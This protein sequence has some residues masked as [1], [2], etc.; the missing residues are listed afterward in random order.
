MSSKKS[1]SSAHHGVSA[2]LA[3]TDTATKVAIAKGYVA[4]RQLNGKVVGVWGEALLR[5]ADGEVRPLKTGDVVKKGDVVL[6]AQDGIIQIEGGRSQDLDRIIASVSEGKPETAPAAGSLGNDPFEPG[7]RVD[8]VTESVTPAS[9]VL[10]PLA[11]SFMQPTNEQKQQPLFNAPPVAGTVPG[12]NGPVTDPN[13][14]PSTGH[15][16][17]LTTMG[18][19]TAGRVMA[20]D[21]NNDTLSFAP[22]AAPAHGTVVINPD[23]T[24]TYTPNPTYKGTDSFSVLVS[25]GHGGTA[26]SVID[27]NV[28]DTPSTLS[29]DTKTVPE[30]TA[31]MG[32]VL[33]N[34]TDPD[35]ALSVAS[36]TVND[37][38]AAPGV[39]TVIASVG[40]ITLLADGTYSFVPAPNW[41][42]TVPQISYT[43]NTGVTS[44][45]NI[46]ITPVSDSPAVSDDAGTTPEDTPITLDVLAND[47]DPDAGTTLTITE[48]NGQPIAIGTPVPLLG[49][50]G[51]PQGQISLTPEG[52][53]VFMPAP[54]FNGPVDFSY[55]VT[56]GQGSVQ[57]QVKLDVTPVNDPP[58]ATTDTATVPANTPVSLDLLGN[59]SDPD[60]EPL[61]ITA[62]NGQPVT[63]G[64]PVVIADPAGTPMGHLTVNADGTV[65]FQSVPGYHGPAA[66]TYTVADPSGATSTAPVTLDVGGINHAP[67]AAPDTNITTED[68]T[69]TIPAATG[70]IRGVGADTDVDGDSLS[71]SAVGFGAS[72]GT[73][74]QPMAAT[75]GS[76]TLKADGSYTYT[77]N[78]A[79]QALDDGES[80]ADVFTY[81]VTDPAGQTATTTLTITVTG[82]NDA[83]V[84]VDDADTTLFNTP[85]TIPVLANDTDVDGEPL[86]ITA[87]SGQ[88]IAVGTP[89]TLKDP[90][91]NTIGQ[92]SLNADGTLTFMPAPD[93]SGPVDFS[94]TVSDGAAP[95]TGNVHVVVGP[96]HPP[97]A[98]SEVQ[99]AF[100]DTP[101]T[102]DP[103]LDDTDADGDKLT[104]TQINS[105][106][107]AATHP[108]SL[109]EGVLSM[110]PN[111][112]LT[113]TP[114]AN[115]NGPVNFNYTVDDGHGGTS[116]ATVTLNVAPVND[117][118]KFDD[119]TNPTFDPAT[120][121]YAVTTPEDTPVSGQVKGSDVDGDPLTYAKAA[122]PAH[123]TVAVNPDGTWT[124][125]PGPSYNGSDVF[126]VTVSDGHGGT[127]TSTITIGIT[128]VNDA[129]K[130]DDPTNPTFDPATG[131][132]AVTTPEDTPVSGQ[133]KG[134]DV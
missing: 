94:Y 37:V 129:P 113:F 63:P 53:L 31:A 27:I 58:V 103:R 12:P 131:N 38:Q 74:G 42:G 118:P 35:D 77:P 54:H 107:I 117:A 2:K 20:T 130:F 100:E 61:H 48:I 104:I 93:F 88:P 11:Q 71:V 57:A 109:P 128:P 18:K 114:N 36:Y 91:G 105:Q 133:V 102:F 50:N 66:F 72:A 99:A 101:V 13:I 85:V 14:D 15:Y 44:T 126:T 108:V 112:S 16:S 52:K 134:S 69:L 33:A 115:F 92:V 40:S 39:T 106:A 55:T 7:L 81:T 5:T 9:M 46:A 45:L 97:V 10:T 4:S 47:S 29:P 73:V 65:T 43:T 90:V 83:P 1:I 30:D 80:Q 116:V 110:N 125:T 22:S 89:V 76:L 19:A 41:N 127:A 6:T 8:R 32:N 132:Y 60:Q 21:P 124:Y 23:G 121:N 59:D 24:W 86:T 87:I 67:V 3:V 70:V 56:D 75:W 78:T 51:Q 17:N 122:D 120:G 68:A 123:G 49:A 98:N 119:P 64:T 62:V 28:V 34:D 95:V 111:G 96:N 82:A 84:V 25:D 79:A 26:I